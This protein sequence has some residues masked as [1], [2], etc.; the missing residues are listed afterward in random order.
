M[1][2]KQGTD[3]LCVYL[4]QQNKYLCTLLKIVETY[5]KKVETNL[6]MNSKKQTPFLHSWNLFGTEVCRTF[7][8]WAVLNRKLISTVNRWIFLLRCAKPGKIPNH[9]HISVKSAQ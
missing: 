2:D 7:K 4:R 3:R 9:I 6:Q 5:I 8:E 1:K